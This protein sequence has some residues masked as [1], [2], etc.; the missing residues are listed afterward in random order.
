MRLTPDGLAPIEGV[1]DY[2]HP[3]FLGIRTADAFY[4]FLGRNA[5]GAPVGIT[6]HDF[7]STPDVDGW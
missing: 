6:L 5:F 4:R 7:S 1:V 3:N 2:L